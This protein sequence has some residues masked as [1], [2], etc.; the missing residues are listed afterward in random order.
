MPNHPGGVIPGEYRGRL[1]ARERMDGFGI[2]RVWLYATPKKRARN[3]MANYASFTATASLFGSMRGGVDAVVASSPPLS[4]G[5]A[6]AAL[7]LRHRVPWVLDVRDLWPDVAAFVGEVPEGS[8]VYRGSKRVEHRLYRSASAVVTTTEPFRQ[9]IMER[10]ARRVEVIPNGTTATYLD[11]AGRE[12][13][14]E[15]LGLPGDRFV[16]TYAGNLGLAQG[17]DAAVEAA[18]LL[19]DGF[20]LLLLGD[21]PMRDRLR[22]RAAALPD[23]TVSFRDP[24]PPVEAAAVMRASDALL[25]P[26]AAG[27]ELDHFIPSKLFDSTGVG[28]PVVVATGGESAR[29]TGEADAALNVPPGDPQAIADAVRRLRDEPELARGIGERGHR[30]AASYDRAKGAEKLGRLLE[31]L[32]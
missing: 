1:L 32:V 28:R 8:L 13:D 17:L 20:Q 12:P 31:E 30:F 4:V 15:G 23:G 10:G 19:G 18:A 29:L 5:S 25:V 7:A 9:T 26:L 3:R 22:E 24:V 6:G 11:L 27:T 21:G 16:W 14:R 2:R